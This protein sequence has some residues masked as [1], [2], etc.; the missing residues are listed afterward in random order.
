MWKNQL[1]LFKEN[2][3]LS[4]NKLAQDIGLSKQTIVKICGLD[5][6]GVLNM[7]L[8]NFIIL[9]KELDVNMTAGID[10][11]AA[12]RLKLTHKSI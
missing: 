1:K 7:R 3:S 8:K 2:H 5:E 4:Y 6:I 11:E 9:D 10:Y 12:K